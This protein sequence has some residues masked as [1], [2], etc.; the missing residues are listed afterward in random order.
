MAHGRR[1]G[2]GEERNDRRLERRERR[3]TTG[4]LL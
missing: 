1:I 4:V 3:G 2:G